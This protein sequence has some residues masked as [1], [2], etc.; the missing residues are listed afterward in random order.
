MEAIAPFLVDG[1]FYQPDDRSKYTDDPGS[2]LTIRAFAWP[3]LLQAAGLATLSGR[4]AGPFAGRS[5]GAG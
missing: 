2:D 1:D 5:Q 4:K 3:C